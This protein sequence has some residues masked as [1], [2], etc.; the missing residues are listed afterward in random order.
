MYY[1]EGVS[2]WKQ[3][4]YMNKSDK[5][6]VLGWLDFILKFN[7]YV[8]HRKKI[9]NLFLNILFKI[10]KSES[11]NESL[12]KIFEVQNLEKAY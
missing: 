7:F 11:E 6:I 5:Y 4:I 9:F 1:I 3:I 12:V 10:Y 2:E 8:I